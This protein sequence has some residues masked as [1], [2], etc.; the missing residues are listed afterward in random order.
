MIAEAIVP[1]EFRR[2][3]AIQRDRPDNARLHTPVSAR[4]TKAAER[5]R[6][7][8]QRKLGTP[9]AFGSCPTL[10]NDTPSVVKLKE[11]MTP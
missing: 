7:R 5:T 4:T 11:R 10:S 6:G 8:F 1:T 2:C 9:L 3:N